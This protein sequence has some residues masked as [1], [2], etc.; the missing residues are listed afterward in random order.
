MPLLLPPPPL[1]R[2]LALSL[3]PCSGGSNNGGQR[4]GRRKKQPTSRVCL[5]PLLC[6]GSEGDVVTGTCDGQ[7][8][9]IKMLGPDED[10]MEAFWCEHDAYTALHSVQG[11]IVPRL[12][13]AGH[14]TMGVYVIVTA[15]ISGMPLSDLEVI[16]Q[17]VAKAA[18]HALERV[19]SACPGLCHGDIRLQNIMLVQEGEEG[20]ATTAGAMCMVIDFGRACFECS[21]Q[22]QRREVQ[23]LASLLRGRRHAP[24]SS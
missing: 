8:A 11:E 17:P 15:R 18:V 24:S 1:P 6:E 20:A 3:L 5:G 13:V 10:G 23:Q 9:V 21:K 7:P 14:Y 4:R 22:E 19:H 2:P 12:L 16:P